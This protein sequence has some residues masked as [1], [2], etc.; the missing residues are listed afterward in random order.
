V[1]SFRARRD[2]W[3]V[4]VAALAILASGRATAVSSERFP[5]TKR[6]TLLVA[7]AVVAVLVVVGRIRHITPER[8]EAAVATHYPVAATAV[9][10]QRG[11]Q[12]PLYN[13][14]NWGGY[15]I[16]RLP[17]LPVAMDGR[18][19]LHGD[20]RIERSLQTWS[21]Q[22]GWDTDP[23]L[24]TAHLVMT[25]V[26]WPLASLLRLDGRFELVYE[27][28]IAAVFI[29]RQQLAGATAMERAQP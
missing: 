11:Y 17:H 25:G 28:A 29:K 18:T 21:G 19:N 1:L 14:F 16:W 20:E 2:V 10:A 12:G 26:T 5:L 6:R 3:F 9:M 22:R 7:V 24:T 13:H 8:L 15:L 23:E 27:D 4:V